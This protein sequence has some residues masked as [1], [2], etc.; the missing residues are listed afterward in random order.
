MMDNVRP[1]GILSSFKEICEYLPAL[2]ILGIITGFGSYVTLTGALIVSVLFFLLGRKYNFVFGVTI[3]YA[4]AAAFFNSYL[5]GRYSTLLA[6]LFLSSL[7]LIIFSFFNIS[8]KMGRIIPLYVSNG[9]IT[10]ALFSCAVLCLPLMTGEK[11]FSSIPLMLSSRAGFF[12]DV[13]E[14]AVV[15]SVLTMVIYHY[16]SKLKL[17]CLPCACLAVFCAG[18][19]NLLYGFN[20]DNISL[21]F[22]GF[23]NDSGADFGNFFELLFFAFVLALLSGAEIFVNLRGSKK[24]QNESKS[25]KKLF[26]LSGFSSIMAAFAGS[27]GGAIVKPNSN[28]SKNLTLVEA[29]VLL[30]F[31]I[32]FNEIAPFVLIPSVAAI[33]TVNLCKIAK[34][35]I[36]A[37]KIKTRYPKVIFYLCLFST[38]YNIVFGVMVAAVFSLLIK[39]PNKSKKKEN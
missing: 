36:L 23:L 26:L 27:V 22:H 1:C 39:T 7:F 6:L 21:G 14:N 33:L 4:L 5:G 35:K 19:I 34:N 24:L 3:V 17:K 2:F 9:F 37:Q 13:N 15:I 20:L 11:T 12:V 31:T 38:L 10:G 18:V 30:I 25:P 28:G 8:K 29:V 32:F 16:L